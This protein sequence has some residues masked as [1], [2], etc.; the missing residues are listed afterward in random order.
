[1]TT[2]DLR[3][4]HTDDERVEA[5]GPRHWRLTLS[6]GGADRYKLAQ[7][8]DYAT[9]RRSGFSW[10]AP[11]RL[12]LRARAS[13]ANLPGT[14][15]FG[16]WND[17]FALGMGGSKRLLPTAPNAAWFFYASAANHLALRDDHPAHGFLAATF[18]AQPLA[19]LALLLGAPLLPLCFWPPGAAL[20]RRA[21]RYL[22]QDDATRLSAEPTRWHQYELIWGVDAVRTRV[23]GSELWTT[24]VVP[25]PPLGL[26]IW[27]DNQYAALAP[28]DRLRFGTQGI[29]H[30]AWLEVADLA[31]VSR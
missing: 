20:A 15:G 27:I 16:F 11:L 26:V 18:A 3:P 28:G 13:S 4:H 30:E 8:D 25:R 1:M 19:G 24:P 7:L 6:P 12:T 9:L 2:L 22:V 10:R 14:W 29:P 17:P 5:L 21:A 23:N 31:I